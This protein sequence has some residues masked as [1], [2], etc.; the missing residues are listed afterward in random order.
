MVHPPAPRVD[1]HAQLAEQ[2]RAHELAQAQAT[3]A[4][5]QAYSS[6]LASSQRAQKEREAAR[7]RHPAAK[8][9]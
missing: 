2:H 1:P 6:S 9:L 5:A 8:V 4:Y 7:G 3:A